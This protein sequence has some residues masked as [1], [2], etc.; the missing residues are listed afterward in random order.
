MV[1]LPWRRK[2]S[3]PDAGLATVTAACWDWLDR[4]DDPDAARQQLDLSVVDGLWGDR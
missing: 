2:G 4:Q 3:D 1:V